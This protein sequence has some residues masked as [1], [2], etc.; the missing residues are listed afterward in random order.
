MTDIGRSNRQKDRCEPGPL[1]R[2][3]EQDDQGE[4]ARQS[5]TQ[6]SK[7]QLLIAPIVGRP[8]EKIAIPLIAICLRRDQNEKNSR[9]VNLVRFAS[10]TDL[11]EP[12]RRFS[13]R[14][15]IEPFSKATDGRDDCRSIYPVLSCEHL[16]HFC[17]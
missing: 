1:G 3:N 17:L 7:T 6:R 2:C 9:Q 11:N 16:L 13:D 12:C 14:A 15:R 8:A 4:T 5:I 10:E